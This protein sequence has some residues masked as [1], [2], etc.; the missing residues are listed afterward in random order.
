MDPHMTVCSRRDRL[1]MQHSLID[2]RFATHI[3]LVPEAL[4]I[5]C[6]RCTAQ[7]GRRGV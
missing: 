3:V 2:G 1:L 4:T 6:G 7:L 5:G